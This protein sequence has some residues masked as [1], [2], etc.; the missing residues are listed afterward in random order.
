ML[1]G[2]DQAAQGL[3]ASPPPPDMPIVS[4][5]ASGRV[6][7]RGRAGGRGRAAAEL[8][9]GIKKR[10]GVEA[11]VG[12]GGSQGRGA[13]SFVWHGKKAAQGPSQLRPAAL[14][15]P[16]HPGS[17]RPAMPPTLPP[18]PPP[19]PPTHPLARH[20]RC[21]W[22]RQVEEAALMQKAADAALQKYGRQ[23]QLLLVVLPTRDSRELVG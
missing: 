10:A 19:D 11:G 23:A 4:A 16:P 5:P 2:L 17:C 18:P 21:P 15:P 3:K 13:Q 14:A 22:P 8:L 20:A 9:G 1:R 7:G 12:V 6:S